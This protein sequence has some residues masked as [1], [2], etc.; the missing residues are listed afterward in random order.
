MEKQKQKT[1]KTRFDFS[2]GNVTI[3]VLL[4]TRR[5]K[6]NGLFPVTYRV[7]NNR[8]QVRYKSGYDLTESEWEIIETTK[9]KALI[10]KRTLII[11]GLKEI[12]DAVEKLIVERGFSFE[13]LHKRLSYGKSERIFKAFDIR[14]KELLEE[15]R[16]GSSY[17]FSTAATSFRKFAKEELTFCEIT[18]SLLTKYEKWMLEN[19][20]SFTTIGMYLRSI[21]V[22]M[23]DGITRGIISQAQY[24]F[25]KG[26]Y[27]IPVGSGRKLALTIEQIGKLMSTK[28]NSET[29]ERCRD[30]W[31]FSYLCNGANVYDILRLKYSDISEGEI[32]W[33]RKKTERT[34]RRKE[35]I[36]A[37]LLPEMKK[38][39]KKWGNP[40]RKQEQYIF[41]FLNNVNDPVQEKETV[42]NTTRLIN[43]KMILLGKL[44]NL[45]TIT[46]Y[47]AR[48]SYATV[49]KRSGANIAYISES[50]GHSDQRITESYLKS[51]EKNERRRNANKLLKF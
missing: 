34:S 6:L 42:K 46:T 36:V 37:I 35:K 43:K 29:E 30:L 17:F 16:V 27:E 31:F 25:G 22:I 38:I 19:K 50:L 32:T 48:H 44:L 20:R 26:L 5:K 15:G 47:T 21:R 4:E 12:E 39:I 8:K 13:M 49:L 40:E 18:P 23:N 14:A 1:K 51:F 41:P 45:G 2:C 7:T 33:Y 9:L 28:V 3:A 10:K 24:P 11:S